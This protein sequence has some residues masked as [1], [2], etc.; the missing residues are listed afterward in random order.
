MVGQVKSSKIILKQ[1]QGSILT[2]TSPDFHKEAN[3][4]K[5]TV[6]LELSRIRGSMLNVFMEKWNL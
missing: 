5:E 4:A 2:V 6:I 1:L 3:F